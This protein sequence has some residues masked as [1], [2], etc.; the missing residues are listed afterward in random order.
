MNAQLTTRSL[1][2]LETVIENG[3]QTFA[4]VGDALFTI[5]DQRLYREQ[6]FD[7]F[8]EYCQKRWNWGRHYA[9][10][11]I[12]AA[13]VVRNLVPIGTKPLNEAQA[14]E[15]AVLEPDEQLEV[16]AEIDFSKVTAE[17][18]RD[19]T[20]E[21]QAQKRELKEGIKQ[22]F[23]SPAKAREEAVRTGE[24][25]VASNG[26]IIQ[27]IT[28]EAAAAQTV[29]LGHFDGAH[30]FLEWQREDDT[31]PPVLA[32]LIR[33]FPLWRSTELG[34]DAEIARAINW[35]KQLGKELSR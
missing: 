16:A 33:K 8:E 10:R 21:F 25:V 29:S 30:S 19:R 20:R 26:K 3:L 4:E 31:E 1:A 2:E 28:K 35:W 14:R 32:A 18:I 17:Q 12:A 23:L 22:K 34:T 15:L 9:N 11:Q 7:T 13:Q 6:G 27:P 24:P 5:R